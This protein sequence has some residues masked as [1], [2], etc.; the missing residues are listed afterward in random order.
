MVVCFFTEKGHQLKSNVQYLSFV[1]RI[2]ERLCKQMQENKSYKHLLCIED[3]LHMV[4][5]YKHKGFGVGIGS[6]GGAR[7]NCMLGGQIE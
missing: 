2:D 4:V 3:L 5:L 6:I 1:Q 7:S